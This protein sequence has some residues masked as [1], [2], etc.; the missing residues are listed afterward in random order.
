MPRAAVVRDLD[1]P[2]T[3]EE[4]VPR[5]LGRG[6]VLVR[7]VACGVCH[8]DLSALDRVYPVATPIILGH[9]AAGRV[10]EVGEGVTSVKPGD[11]VVAMWRPACGKCRYCRKGR[12]HL[13]RLGDD[14]GAAAVGRL[15]ADGKPLQILLGVGGFSEVQILAEN[16]LVKIDESV[17][18]DR[19]ALLGCA[20][21]TG[22]GAALHAARVAEGDEVAV[23]GCG[24]VGLNVIQ[25]C[26]ISGAKTIVA[27]DLDPRKL[28]NAKAFGA[29]HVIDGRAPDLHK[30]VRALTEEGQGVDVAFDA[31]GSV[32]LDELALNCI[33]RGGEVVLVGIAN[34]KEKFAVPQMATVM[35]ERRIRGTLAG[36]AEISRA[37]PEM[38]DL[39]KA[40]R[41]RLDELVTKTYPLD[42][43][44]EA[45]ADLRA[46]TNARGLI[47]F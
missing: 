11:P 20:V 35:Q 42:A 16:Q 36:S 25:G 4:I 23:F 18:L 38:I 32:P 47:V 29:T 2:L 17:P 5:A 33:C 12:G 44:N 43:I 7:M 14:P 1:A 6:E 31:V 21:I 9:E 27:I 24:G 34:F 26:A 15:T 22:V 41:L 19:A 30:A 3:V 39:Y 37:I 28:E 46:G 45:F 8:S 40:K 10:E 13:C